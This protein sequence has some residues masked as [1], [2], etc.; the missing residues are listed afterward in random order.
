MSKVYMPL[1]RLTCAARN[2][3]ETHEA[4]K[5]PAASFVK[6]PAVGAAT[7][8]GEAPTETLAGTAATLAAGM[9]ERMKRDATRRGRKFMRSETTLNRPHETNG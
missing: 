3:L 6:P 9:A 5:L 4:L 1:G 2:P 8:A 7:A